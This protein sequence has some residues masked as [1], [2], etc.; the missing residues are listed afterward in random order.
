MSRLLSPRWILAHVVVAGLVIVFALLGFWQLS[1]LD[2]RRQLNATIEARFDEEPV[3]FET[4]QTSTPEDIEYR[5]VLLSGDF[6]PDEEILV[7]SQVHN[8]TAGFHVIT[9]VETNP[10]AGVLVNRGWV[11]LGLDSV[12]VDE[13]PPPTPQTV[14]E[15][16]I[17]LSQQRP[18]LGREEPPGYL[19]V[20]NRVDIPRIQQQVS[21]DLAEVYVVLSDTQSSD[22]P[23]AIDAPDF[24]DEGSHLSYAV[25]WFSFATITAIGYVFLVRRRRSA[26][27]PDGKDLARSSTTS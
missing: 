15:G 23:V 27:H 20:V 18:T 9:P 16:W 14:V 8:G 2:E 7:R 24:S 3:P 25:Q 21:I 11:P 5:R 13:A 10:G 6:M 12:P 4:L 1:R 26:D 22:L 17:H 19:E